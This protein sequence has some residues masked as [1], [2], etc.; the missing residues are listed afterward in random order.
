MNET[1]YTN[2]FSDVWRRTYAQNETAEPDAGGG[3][4]EDLLS[5]KL[6]PETTAVPEATFVPESEPPRTPEPGMNPTGGASRPVKN[7]F[8]QRRKFWGVLGV[9]LGV[10]LL[11]VAA[12]GVLAFSVYQ[13]AQSI[14]VD[15]EEAAASGRAVYTAF[16]GQNL[17]EMKSNLI[18]VQERLTAAEGKYDRLSWAGRLPV[19]SKYYQD[20][21]HGFAAGQSGVSAAMKVVAAIEPHA[22]VLGFTG[23]GTFTGGTT[24]NRIALVLQTLGQIT[25]ELDKITVDI[26]ELQ[27]NLAEINP[28][29]YPESV[30]GR[31]VRQYIFQAQ[32]AAGAAGSVLTEARPVIEQLPTVAGA[33]GR[34]KY[35][36]LFQNDNE[37]RPTGGFLTAYAVVFVENG[38]VTPEKS[39]DIYELDKKF[40]NKPPI[41]PE[42]GRFLIT[43]KRW[44]LRDMNVD[45]NF[46]NSMQQF[47]SNFM[48]VPG[49]A[50]DIDGI[51]AID[52]TILENMVEILGPIEVPGYGTFSAQSDR[53]C[54]C[55]QI[56]YALSEIIDRPTPYLRENRK[57]ILA[58]MM[59]SLLKKTYDAPHDQWPQLADLLWKGVQGRHVQ[60]F[61][62]NPD[63]QAAAESINAA[64]IVP[65][66]PSDGSD[67]LAVIDA[68][69]A[70]AKSN[71]FIET[72]ADV[73]IES[74]EGGKVKK[75]VELTYRNTHPPSNCNLEKG[76]LCLNG[77]LND[78]TRW[79]VPKGTTIDEALGLEPG[80][81]LNTDNPD[82]D[83]IEG[84]FRLSPNS[85][86]K[87]RITYTAPYTKAGDY[88]IRLQKQGG[89]D[90]IPYRLVTPWGEGEVTLDKDVT[91]T[92]K[93]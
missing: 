11:L 58:P 18:K 60:F 83:I 7:R 35:L 84:V 15:L 25:P 29:D 62:P 55:P 12:G 59:Q 71:L 73:K 13:Q 31:P 40:R 91:V 76:E 37:L 3:A 6:Q 19:A 48:Q 65:Q 43:E 87:V 23:E 34:K 38:V 14:R 51:I 89:T 33:K 16:K 46:K 57:G 32:A 67:Y 80:F 92:I 50:R 10:L 82:F 17:V 53:R 90:P 49:E 27:K 75:Q 5:R 2:N 78:W 54:D 21:K 74:A 85:Q 20:G 77:M 24:E 72:S 4:A 47:Y 93:R 66:I 52:T 9:V 28:A 26:N 44:N 88:A 69:L 64:G 56:I 1:Q 81:K 79:Y 36:I 63:L 30:Q 8:W 70:G 61:F 45:P 42:L 22:D 41:P 68:N 86:T 39:D